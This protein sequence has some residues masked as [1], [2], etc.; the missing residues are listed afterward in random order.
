MAAHELLCQNVLRKRTSISKYPGPCTILEDL[1]IS[2]GLPL[3]R[4]NILGRP[5]SA[6]ILLPPCSQAV[7]GNLRQLTTNVDLRGATGGQL[8]WAWL[9]RLA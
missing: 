4:S 6:L 1:V 3:Y 5:L 2:V 9:R 8:F 7:S